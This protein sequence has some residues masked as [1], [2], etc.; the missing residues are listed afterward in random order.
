MFHQLSHGISSVQL[1][2]KPME[3]KAQRSQKYSKK[4]HIQVQ[5]SVYGKVKNMA[6]TTKIFFV[7]IGHTAA[8][9]N[10]HRN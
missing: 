9:I 7:K 8:F 1:F 4:I 10:V 5:N 6:K 2:L 3:I